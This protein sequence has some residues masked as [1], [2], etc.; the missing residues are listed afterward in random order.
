MFGVV[1]KE[2]ILFDI[3]NINK[4]LSVKYSQNI[5]G[6]IYLHL[7]HPNYS[8]NSYEKTKHIKPISL[9][10]HPVCL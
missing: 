7:N 4:I 6:Y 10:C 3:D 5:L 9:T 2:E 1:I 8:D